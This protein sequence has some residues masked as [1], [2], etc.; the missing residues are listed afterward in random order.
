MFIGSN[1]AQGL[2]CSPKCLEERIVDELSS[3]VSYVLIRRLGYH[4]KELRWKR[5]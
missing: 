5:V 1:A 4:L 3:L 2:E